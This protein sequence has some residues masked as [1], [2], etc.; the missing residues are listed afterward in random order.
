MF[1]QRTVYEGSGKTSPFALGDQEALNALLMSEIPAE[2]VAVQPQGGE[3]FK[4]NFHEVEVVD[5][6]TLASRYDGQPVTLLHSTGS[7]KPWERRGWRRGR[8]RN[9]YARLLRRLLNG[10]D[11][12]IRVSG[13]DLPVWLRSGMGARSTTYLLGASDLLLSAVFLPRRVVRE[14][15]KRPG[16]AQ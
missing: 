8:W 14:G 11:I 1:G 2:A 3:V 15:R 6:G 10:P 16:K 4:K 7:P 13:H 12:E 5:V 9:A